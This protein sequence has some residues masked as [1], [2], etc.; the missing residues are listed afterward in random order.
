[1]N[2][3]LR[4]LGI[5]YFVFEI[6]KLEL[7]FIIVEVFLSEPGVTV[8]ITVYISAKICVTSAV[9]SSLHTNIFF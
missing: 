8:S 7:I 9:S 3:I 1:M 6:S 2:C 4:D 5:L